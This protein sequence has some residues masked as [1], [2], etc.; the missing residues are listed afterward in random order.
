[1]GSH[2]RR[3]FVWGWIILCCVDWPVHH[4]M[5]SSIPGL[6]PLDA[7][8]LPPRHDPQNHL[9]PRTTELHS[10]VALFDPRS[11]RPCR[12]GRPP[13]KMLTQ[14]RRIPIPHRGVNIRWCPEQA[15]NEKLK[16]S[17]CFSWFSGLQPFGTWSPHW[18]EMA[19]WG[20]KANYKSHYAP[21]G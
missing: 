9:Q 17:F 18:K 16:A 15:T 4:R 12:V 13:W 2:R 1:M 14:K 6:Y 20:Y 5:F 10:S 3:Y 8:A 7:I 11:L 21:L 19:S